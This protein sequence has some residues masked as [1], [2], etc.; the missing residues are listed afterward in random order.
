MLISNMPIVMGLK[1]T[2][3]PPNEPRLDKRCLRGNANSKDPDQLAEIYMLFS[4]VI[5][6]LIISSITSALSM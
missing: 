5:V 2:I 4:P 6:H 3:N 1:T